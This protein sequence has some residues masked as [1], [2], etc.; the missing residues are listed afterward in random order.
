MADFKTLNGYYVKDE[1]ARLQAAANASDISALRASVINYDLQNIYV[2]Q[3]NGD[4]SYDGRSSATAYKT[5]DRALAEVN[6]GYINIAVKLMHAGNYVC[7][8]PRFTGFTWHMSAHASGVSVEFTDPGTVNGIVF[9]SM[10]VNWSVK[11][12]YDQQDYYG[13]T[14][15]VPGTN[16]FYQDGGYCLF[17]NINFLNRWTCHGGEV[18]MDGAHI[19]SVQ[20]DRAVFDMRDIDVNSDD[21]LTAIIDLD[22]CSTMC[23]SGEWY[24]R[25]VISHCSRFMR[26]KQSKVY[27]AVGVS[28]WH[29]EAVTL[30]PY[31]IYQ[32][33]MDMTSTSALKTSLLAMG[34]DDYEG[35]SGA[36][37]INVW[38]TTVNQE[39]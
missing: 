30:P 18:T 1:A 2:D 11:D 9:Y 13:F 21:G 39:P 34:T 19:S 31:A 20:G 12:V 35:P 15:S 27:W 6:K 36:G 14:V 33:Q 7:S 17:R 38:N 10:H 32:Y 3:L 29:N 37:S 16:G 23:A 22:H 25:D 28:N 4:D 5:L 8:K 26:I 24:I